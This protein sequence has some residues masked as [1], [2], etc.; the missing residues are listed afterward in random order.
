M[1]GRW[2]EWLVGELRGIDAAGTTRRLQPMVSPDGRTVVVS[3][4]RLLLA[5]GNGYLGLGHD[6]EVLAAARE[7]LES[8]GASSQAS[9][10]VAGDHPLHHSLE[11]ECAELVGTPCALVVGSGYLANVGLLR[12]L[13]RDATIV[14]DEWN[15]ASI[16]DGCRAA[17]A[18]AVRRYRHGDAGEANRA[19]EEAARDGGRALLVTESLFSV[20]GDLAPLAALGESCT[21]RGALLVV[22]EAHGLGV[23]GPTGRGG[24]EEAGRPGG[25]DAIV[26]TLGKALGGYGAFVGCSPELRALLVTR[27]RTA[28]YST[29]LPPAVLAG[30]LAAVRRLRRDAGLVERLRLNASALRG[31]LA[32]AGFQVPGEPWS[33]ILPLVVGGN[34]ETLA[35]AGRLREAGVL[36][37]ALRPPTVPEGT[38]RLRLSVSAAHTAEDVETIAA[39]VIRCVPGRR[40][41]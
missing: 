7:A 21:A 6:P 17:G 32:A 12:V 3:G 39:A 15:H 10:L 11:Q 26:G 29:A 20:D 30:C 37:A 18:R 35:A 16:V 9:R 36:V 22:D 8:S 5:A 40:G 31:A 28:V 1:T 14:S 4:R 24:L 25:A 27:L 34:Q 38:A 19:L 33:P 23:A 13:G 41:A 2:D